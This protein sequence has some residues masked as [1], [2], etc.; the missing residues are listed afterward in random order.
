MTANPLSTTSD[1]HYFVIYGKLISFS[2][3]DY[4]LLHFSK[5]LTAPMLLF[6]NVNYLLDEDII[7]SIFRKIPM[8][9]TLFIAT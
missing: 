6:V 1:I 4:C 2:W 8:R 3:T 9:Q 5:D 7:A